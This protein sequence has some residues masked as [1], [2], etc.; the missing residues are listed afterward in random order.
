MP[1]HKYQDDDLFNPETHHEHSDV[2]VRPLLWLIAIFIV[3]SFVIYFLILFLYKGM[4]SAE[5]KRMDPPETQVA[6]PA[7]ASVP[8]NQPFLQPFPRL[9]AEK[10]VIVPN[11]NTP[12]TDMAG[13]RRSQ[14]HVLHT[15]GWVDKQHGVVHIPIEEAKKLFAA[16]AAASETPSPGALVP[17]PPAASPAAPAPT[18]AEPAV[19]RPAPAPTT[20][21]RSNGGTP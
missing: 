14:E 16:R 12:A 9:D 7:D 4:V 19:D 8:K 6:R 20:A 5:R 15:Y 10:R 21:R 17:G 1:E 2:P 3:L 13:M 18:T 11:R